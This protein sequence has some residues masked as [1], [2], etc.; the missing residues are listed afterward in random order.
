VAYST[1]RCETFSAYLLG[2]QALLNDCFGPPG[3]AGVAQGSEAGSFV[4][5]ELPNAERRAGFNGRG[6]AGFSDSL[7]KV[8]GV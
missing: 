2:R 5:E 8:L 4:Y 1:R 3:S 7:L 6:L